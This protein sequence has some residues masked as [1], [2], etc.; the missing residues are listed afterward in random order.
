MV[1][2]VLFSDVSFKRLAHRLL[3]LRDTL[4]L[5]RIVTS[6]IFIRKYT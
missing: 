2:N 4:R 5:L 3:V 6:P 1:R